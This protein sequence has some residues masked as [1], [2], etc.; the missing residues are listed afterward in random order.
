MGGA[1]PAADF[2]T[3]ETRKVEIED[4]QIIVVYLV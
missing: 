1:H 2:N 3:V 4:D